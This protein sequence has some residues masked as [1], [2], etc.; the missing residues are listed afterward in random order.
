MISRP[1]GW[2]ELS[3]EQFEQ[4]LKTCADWRRESYVGHARYYYAHNKKTFGVIE[5]GILFVH[6]EVAKLFT[7]DNQ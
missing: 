2:P 3:E 4:H 6:P 5:R 1:P 7:T